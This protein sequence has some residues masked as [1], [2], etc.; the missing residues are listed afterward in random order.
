[1]LLVVIKVFVNVPHPFYYPF[2]LQ[3]LIWVFILLQVLQKVCDFE[4]F[5]LIGLG[6]AK[7]LL[8]QELF[9]F[10]NELHETDQAVGF[11]LDQ[12][13]YPIVPHVHS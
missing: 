9:E 3:L 10:L 7:L 13:R 4:A 12:E 5:C 11:L 8:D 6:V 1:M 2:L